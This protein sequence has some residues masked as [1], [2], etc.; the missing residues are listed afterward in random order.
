MNELAPNI[1]ALNH[2]NELAPNTVALNHMNELVPCC[3]RSLDRSL[4]LSILQDT[5]PT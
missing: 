1:V 2:M 5:A 4:V 3:I